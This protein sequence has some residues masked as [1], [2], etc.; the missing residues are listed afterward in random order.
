MVVIVQKCGEDFD[1]LSIGIV[2]VFTPP[3]SCLDF[4]AV[5]SQ[6]AR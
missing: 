2:T 4:D 5:V 3:Y 6:A 1:H